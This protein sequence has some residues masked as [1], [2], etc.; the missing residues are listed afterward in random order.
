MKAFIAQNGGLKSPNH[1]LEDQVV[2]AALAKADDGLLR[3]LGLD[4]IR[5]A[6][7]EPSHFFSLQ[8]DSIQDTESFADN[9]KRDTLPPPVCDRCHS[10]LHH[11]SGTPIDHPSLQSIRE[12]IFQSSYKSNH[13]YHVIDAADFP[14]SLI[15]NLHRD[16]ALNPQRSHNRRAKTGKF[17][18]GRR[19]EVSFII[20]RSDLLA[21]KKEQVD[22]LMPYLVQVLRDALSAAGRDIRL[23]NVRC[24]S[25]QRGWWTKEI[26]E[27]IWQRGG[28]SWMVGKVNV[29][30]S[31]LF[32]SVFPKGRAEGMKRLRPQIH[33]SNDHHTLETQDTDVTRSAE[34][35]ARG[36]SNE[37]QSIGDLEEGENDFLLPPPSQPEALFPAMPL[38]SSLPGTTASP[39]R[40]SFGKGKGELVDLPGLFRGDLDASVRKEHKMDLVMRTRA[41]PKQQVIKPG[42]SLLLGGLIRIT[43]TNPDI[44]ILAYPFVP[45]AAHVTSTEK[46]RGIQT[47]QLESGVDDILE[48]GVGSRMA[49]AGSYRL[50]WD[51]TEQRSGPL[52]SPAA[53]GLSA[54]RLPYR[55][56]STDIL[57]E[58]CG[59]VELVAQVRKSQ[60]TNTRPSNAEHMDATES[61]YDSSATHEEVDATVVEVEVFSPEGKHIGCRRP[62]NAWR[63]NG[64]NIST[65]HKRRA[66]PRQ[67]MKGT[68][69]SGKLVRAVH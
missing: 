58:G 7:G 27:D 28:A 8:V 37:G 45:I 11:Q 69:K 31:R 3:E 46:A 59:W 9:T 64:E 23:G 57:I 32:E 24:V 43:P 15:P 47:Q 26:K 6:T 54:E 61:D 60:M 63:F 40:L 5:D 62:L 68:K 17:S 1:T 29:G 56:L 14:L 36:E 21:P 49:S 30:K 39:I 25:S 65:A 13:I 4:K 35:D 16:L 22:S 2:R 41:N 19:A 42:Q 44:V 10:L 33:S 51:I 53:V 20:T 55:V 34:R 12:T 48:A 52:T 66:R 50:E 18:R 38:V 67:S